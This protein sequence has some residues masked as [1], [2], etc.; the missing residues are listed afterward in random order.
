MEKIK[1][2]V[3]KNIKTVSNLNSFDVFIILL[4]IVVVKINSM[5]YNSTCKRYYN[6]FKNKQLNKKV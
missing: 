2:T 3:D 5:I 6:C 1:G 4:K